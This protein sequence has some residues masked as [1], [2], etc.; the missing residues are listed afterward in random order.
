M[1]LMLSDFRYALRQARN[2]PAVALV[3]I[4]LIGFGIA[5]NATIFTWLMCCC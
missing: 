3:I 4:S 2:A 5:A 1:D